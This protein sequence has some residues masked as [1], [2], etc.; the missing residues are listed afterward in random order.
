MNLSTHFTLEELTA[1]DKAV[2]LGIDNTPTDEALDAL[3]TTAAGMERVRD[4]LGDKRVFSTSGY[5]CPK[6]NTATGGASASQHM[7]GEAVDFVCPDF[8]TPMEVCQEVVANTD[9][10]G[11]DQLIMEGTWVHISFSD[12]NRGEVLT[13]T[14]KGGKATYTKGLT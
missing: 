6:L 4:V 11:F 12:R 13:A 2:R 1:S 5:R 14:F 8:G 7:K 9:Y 3:Y 10:V